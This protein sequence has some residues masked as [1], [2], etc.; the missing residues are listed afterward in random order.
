VSIVLD[1][2]KRFPIWTG[3]GVFALAGFLF[4]DYLLGS[5]GDLQVGD[6]FDVPAAARAAA[7]DFTVKDVQHHPCGD[8]HGAEVFFVGNMT[9][10]KAAYPSETEFTA[11]VMA[12]CVPAY[13]S[14]TGRV[15]DT[16]TVYDVQYLLPTTDGWEGGDRS[17]QCYLLRVDRGS[18]KGSQHK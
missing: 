8:E 5:A 15:F 11:Y 3:I 6:C 14:Y 1:L 7:G 4:R 2:V 17:V 16:D 12:R 9:G 18:F 10:D 13:Q